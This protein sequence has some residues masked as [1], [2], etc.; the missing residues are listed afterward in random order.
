MLGTYHKL[1][2]IYCKFKSAY[3]NF[4]YAFLYAQKTKRE[5][6]KKTFSTTLPVLKLFLFTFYKF[7]VITLNKINYITI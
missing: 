5:R 3:V 6:E 2:R 1:K 7:L 4:Y